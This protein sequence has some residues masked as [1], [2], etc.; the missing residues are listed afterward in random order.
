MGLADLVSACHELLDA[1]QLG[2]GD[3]RVT[4]WPD[5]RTLRYYQTCG[6]IAPPLRYAGRQAVYGFDHLLRAVSVKLLQAEG[7]SLAQVQRALASAEGDQLEV[8]VREALQQTAQRPAQV[9]PT[10]GLR[11]RSESLRPATLAAE[12]GPDATSLLAVEL[13]PGVT[14]LI[15]SARVADPGAVL[16]A[17]GRAM[18]PGT[19]RGG[20]A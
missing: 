19:G 7:L 17:L 4:A 1:M 5:A 10:G 13:A 15:D 14:V 8:A 2:S 6:L 9:D 18:G 12:P 3:R 20:Q 16:R 11:E